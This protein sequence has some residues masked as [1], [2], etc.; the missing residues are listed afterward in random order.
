MLVGLAAYQTKGGFSTT[1][2][3]GLTS[4]RGVSATLYYILAYTFMN[5]GAF[6]IVTWLQHRGAGMTL[7][8]F[9]GLAGTKPLA[10]AAMTVF[11]VSLMGVPPL[12]GFY[13][14]YYV[15]LAAID[16]DMLWLALAV[17][18]FSAMSAYYY[19]R[20]VAV[21]YFNSSEKEIRPASTQLLN[22]GI[23][24]MV[25]ATIALGLFSSRLVDLADHWSGA[26]TVAARATGG[27]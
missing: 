10:A 21:M 2:R 18:F 9:A 13:A 3:I 8:D 1:D 16:A 25:V 17:V 4:D 24:G 22:V 27:G 19:L 26:L 7:D 23:A 11:L 6:A 5:I 15:I 20:V 14:K 12:L